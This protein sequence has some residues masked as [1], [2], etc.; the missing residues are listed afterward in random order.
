MFRTRMTLDRMQRNVTILSS[1]LVAIGAVVAISARTGPGMVV[2]AIGALALLVAWAMSPREVVV[3]AGE[4]RVVRRAWPPFRVPL[5]AV[6]AAAP[7][8]T[9]GGRAIRLFGVGGFFGNYGLFSSAAIGR[10]RLYATRG[11]QA[12][13]VRRNDDKLPLVLTPDDVAGTISAIDRRPL[14]SEGAPRGDS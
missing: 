4:L 1:T 8:D 13:I 6:D 11:G 10:F 9:L 2:F 5:A 12:V 7:L 3:D 14:L